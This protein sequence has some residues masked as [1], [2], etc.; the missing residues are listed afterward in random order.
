M[1]FLFGYTIPN[2]HDR[3]LLAEMFAVPTLIPMICLIGT[4]ARSACLY[5]QMESIMPAAEVLPPDKMVTLVVGQ[6]PTVDA[7]LVAGN[8]EQENTKADVV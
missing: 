2:T 7:C 8:E 4:A 1:A 5:H 6:D 3:C